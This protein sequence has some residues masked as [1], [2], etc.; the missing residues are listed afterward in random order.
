MMLA[1]GI[2]LIVLAA[3]WLL[4]KTCLAFNS[5]GGT[6]M[7]LVVYDAAVYPPL[8]A[9]IGAYLL[10]QTRQLNWPLWSYLLLWLGLTAAAAGLIR[11]SEEIGDRRLQ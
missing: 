10:V 7:M 2:G 6:D 5:G 3:A 4:Y 11:V 8:L 1:I 9:T